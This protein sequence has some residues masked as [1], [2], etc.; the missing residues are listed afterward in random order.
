MKKKTLI[1]IPGFLTDSHALAKAHKASSLNEYDPT[2]QLDH[3]AWQKELKNL[4][5]QEV[6]VQTLQWDSQSPVELVSSGL[7]IFV[8]YI[9]L[10]LGLPHKILALAQ[11]LHDSW[12]KAINESDLVYHD[13]CRLVE[14]ASQD[15]E[16]TLLGHSLGGR[17]AL[18]ALSQLAREGRLKRL[19][20]VSAWAPAITIED[21]D[22]SLLE[23]LAQP[24][25]ICFSQEDLV[26]NYLFPLGQAAPLNGDSTDLLNL[27]QTFAL[28]TNEQRALGHIGPPDRAPLLQ[29]LSHD[30]TAKK[31]RHL[32][33]LPQASLLFQES[34]YLAQLLK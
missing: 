4:C 2:A 26:L 15:S 34:T 28:R 7:K 10:P 3:R 5:H 1:I 9:R 30:Y 19:P 22:W 21:L 6:Q 8:D 14:K 24:P 23:T 16:V 31:M 20:Q 29:E 18:K 11:T 33:Y 27:L 12:S 32:N 17:I 25:E 13:L